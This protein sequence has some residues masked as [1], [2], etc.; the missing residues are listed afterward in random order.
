MT[1]IEVRILGVPTLIFLQTPDTYHLK[2]FKYS[3]EGVATVRSHGS[4]TCEHQWK[5]KEAELSSRGIS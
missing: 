2:E 4:E 1:A 3:N 5:Q